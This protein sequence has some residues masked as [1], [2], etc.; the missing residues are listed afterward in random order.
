MTDSRITDCRIENIGLEAEYG[1]GIRLAWGSD[2]NEI[3]GNVVHNTGRGGIFGDHSAELVIRKNRVS[4]SGGDGLGIEIWGGCPR[5]LIEDNTVDH[6]LSVD[7]GHQSAVRRNIVGT[8]RRDSQGL[9]HRDHRSRR[10][11]HRQRRHAGRSHRLVGV[12]SAGEEQRLL[13]LQH[14]PRLRA[15]GRSTPRRDGRHRP[16]LLLPLCFREVGSRRSACPLSERQRTWFSNEREL[17]GA[18]LRGLSVPRQRR[19]GR[20]TRRRRHRCRGLPRLRDHGQWLGRRPASGVM[21][22]AEFSQC[23]VQRNSR[24]N[25]PRPNRFRLPHPSRTS[26]SPT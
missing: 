8:R 4:G 24:D 25:R 3:A 9:R 21:H 14:D 23:R 18:G 13:G 6:W 1:G 10:G 22:V 16:S 11:G 19:P 12:Q 15:V 5:S 2:R 7:R 26:N 17:S 20:A